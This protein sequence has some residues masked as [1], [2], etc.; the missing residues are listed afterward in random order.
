M[1]KALDRSRAED[2]RRGFT[3]QAPTGTIGIAVRYRRAHLRLPG[4]KRTAALS[5]KLSELAFIREIRRKPRCSYWTTC[6][7]SWTDKQQL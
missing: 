1:L 5:L 3:T 2:L 4:Q 6:S 7:L